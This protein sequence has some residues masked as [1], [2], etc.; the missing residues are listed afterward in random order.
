MPLGVVKYSEEN[1]RPFGICAAAKRGGEELLLSEY[2]ITWASSLSI[3]EISCA[4]IRIHE[5]V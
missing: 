2:I 3:C 5:R 4:M 1:E